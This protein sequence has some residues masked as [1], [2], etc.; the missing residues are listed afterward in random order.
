[1]KLRRFL[2]MFA[3]PLVLL[4]TGSI[5]QAQDTVMRRAGALLSQMTQ[6]EKLDLISS[7]R[8]GIPRLRIPPVSF[9]DG[10]NGVGEGSKGVTAFPDAE[11]KSG[12]LFPWLV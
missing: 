6:G 12:Y 2:L 8:A 1:M 5:A 3:T 7:G 11:Q 4:L 10:P 9:I